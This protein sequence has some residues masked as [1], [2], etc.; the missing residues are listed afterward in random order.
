MV[1]FY[2]IKDPRPDLVLAPLNLIALF[3]PIDAT[4]ATT[5]ESPTDGSLD[6]P[7]AYKSLGHFEKKAGVGIGNEFDSKDIEAYGEPE[8]IRI[9]KNKRTTSFE[10]SLFENSLDVL[11]I[12]WTD[13]FSDVTPSE[14]GG[15]VLPAPKQPKN[16]FYRCILLGLDDR[17]DREVW[18][19]WLLPKVQLDKVDNQTLNDDNVIEYKVT[20]KAFKD[21]V[22]GYSVAQGF[23]GPGWRD[24]VHLARFGQ[25]LTSINA[26][27]ASPSVTVSAG[28]SHT[29]Q[30]VVEGNNGINYTPDCT[31][32]S[33]DPTKATVS[34]SGLITGVAT[35][36]TTVTVTK[37][38]LTDTVSVTVT[39]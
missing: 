28:A 25:E 6:V 15:V 26:T 10:V 2:S 8:P 39:S 22:L 5:L 4:P 11:G 12:V 14:F 19:Y 17:N 20:M 1:D 23:A 38:S 16:I 13:D 33:S 31:F 36:S 29:V 27:P 21:P 18:V 35:G 30:L 7:V 34:S 37:G 9:I 3:A 24:I 32:V